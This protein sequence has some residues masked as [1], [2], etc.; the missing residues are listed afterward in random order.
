MSGLDPRQLRDLIIRPVLGALA[1]PGGEPIERLLLG[2]AVHESD[3]LRYIHQKGGGP[4]LSPWQIEPSTAMDALER[5]AETPA[6]ERPLSAL[7]HMSNDWPG[8]HGAGEYEH[9]IE[10]LPGNLYLSAAL[11]RIIYY[12]KPFTL[13]ELGIGTPQQCGRIWKRYWNTAAGKGTEAEFLKH[14]HL[15]LSD[16]YPS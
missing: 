9:L 6:L 1:L 3:G 15:Y 12:L 11:A 2:T 16:L 5:A 4:A 14:W 7:W 10:S 13:E 8:V